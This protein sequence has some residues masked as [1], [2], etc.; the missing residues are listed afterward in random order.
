MRNPFSRSS[1]NGDDAPLEIYGYRGY[2]VALSA[3]WVG[4]AIQNILGAILLT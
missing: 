2:M 1:G 4:L 3:A